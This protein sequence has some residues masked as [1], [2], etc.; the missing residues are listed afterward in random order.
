MGII[1]TAY[2]ADAAAQQ[3]GGLQMIF[4]LVIFG[5]IF[6]FMIF[7]P[8]SKRNKQ[9]RELM[10]SLAKGEE[11]LTSGGLLGKITKVSAESDY[12]VIALNDTNEVTIKKDF[13]VAVLPKG[14]IKSL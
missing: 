8:Q 3:G 2:A 1:S 10:S 7:R 6:Y 14:S 12:I 11:V 4:L 13:I 5:L 9:H